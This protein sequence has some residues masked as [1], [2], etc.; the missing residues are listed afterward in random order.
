MKSCFLPLLF[1][2]IL[3]ELFFPGSFIL[4]KESKIELKDSEAKKILLST[5][6]E[7]YEKWQKLDSE[8]EKKAALLLVKNG[9][10]GNLGKYLL[11]DLPASQVKKFIEISITLSKFYL[12]DSVAVEEA[13]NKIEKLT[14]EAAKN[15]AMDWFLKNEIKIKNGNLDIVYLAIDGKSYNAK[16]PYII[17]YHPL[18]NSYAEVTIEIYSSKTTK[19]PKPQSS[20]LLGSYPLEEEVK[21]I[22]P[23]ILRVKGIME[24]SQKTYGGY[25]WVGNPQIEVVF[26][27]S[28]PKIEAE[29]IGFIESWKNKVINWFKGVK[30][31]IDSFVDVI[32]GSGNRAKEQAVS[33]W[34]K[35]GDFFA[36]MSPFTAK[37][38]P[39]FAKEVKNLKESIIEDK[40]VEDNINEE[41]YKSQDNQDSLEKDIGPENLDK[42]QEIIDNIAEQIDILSQKVAE[43][44]DENSKIGDVKIE[45]AEIGVKTENNSDFESEFKPEPEPES[46]FKSDSDSEPEPGAESEPEPASVPASA[47]YS[48]SSGGGGGSPKPAEPSWCKIAG[49]PLQNKII[50]FEVAWMGDTE[51]ANNEWFSLKNISEKSVNLGKWQIFDKDKQIKI[52]I[53]S[54]INIESGEVYL[55]ERGDNYTGALN[56]TDEAL[57]LFNSNCVLQDQVLAEPD[58]PAGDR[59]NKETMKRADDLAWFD[60]PES[61]TDVASESDNGTVE[62]IGEEEEEEKEEEEEEEEEKNKSSSPRILINEIAWSGTKF[63][64]NDEWIELYNPSENPIEIS[65]WELLFKPAEGEER[66]IKISS[67]TETA[68]PTIGGLGYFLME[69][70][71]DNT[72]ADIK[73]DYIYTG[74]LNDE[75]GVLELRDS[76][77][78]LVDKVDCSADWLAGRKEGRISMERLNL[79]NWVDNNLIIQQGKD[80]GGGKIWGTPKSRNSCLISPIQIHEY[81][82]FEEFDEIT[83]SARNNPY[84]ITGRLIIP[85]EKTLII[86]PGAVVKFVDEY[87]SIIV[88]GTLKALGTAESKVVFTSIQENPAPGSWGV[89]AFGASSRN[90]KLDNVIVEYAGGGFGTPCSPNMAGIY[91]NTSSISLTNSIVRHSQ[92]K[93]IHLVNSSSIID[94]V[95][96]IDNVACCVQAADYG[97]FGILVEG[98]TAEPIIRNSLIK[99]SI[100]GIRVIKKASPIIENNNFEENEK[101][102]WAGEEGYPYFSGNTA[103]NNGFNGVVV[104]G[105]INQNTA[106]QANLPYLLVNGVVVAKDA[107]LTIEPGTVVKFFDGYDTLTIAGTLKALGTAEN[108]IVFTSIQEN[109]APGSWNVLA[110]GASSQNSKLDNVIIEYAGGGFGTPCSPDMTAVYVGANSI[111]LTNSIIRHS[112][113]KG[114]SLINSNSYLNNVEVSDTIKCMDT[115]GGYGVFIEGGNNTLENMIF[116]NNS[117]NIFKDGKCLISLPDPILDTATP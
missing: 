115:Y 22:P 32:R 85:E 28:V 104:W 55:F 80:A 5:N 16:F 13:V 34:D 23:F 3:E 46:E 11:F 93:G 86:E 42:M 87:D 109:P 10:E 30:T 97:G 67:M 117:C 37:I 89:L 27:E 77:G 54:S 12:G 105:M 79:E 6:N 33:V 18:D 71:D 24:N 91:V 83:F 48:S 94:N 112:Q 63:S 95:Q 66:I 100:V 31:I 25:W 99:G 101:A 73:A 50:F 59:E 38:S 76:N 58:W 2:V 96:L 35:A 56:N 43:I 21:D 113:Y 81:L 88:V 7:L 90:S 114:I 40:M 39:D 70:T 68:T 107:V 19:G 106:W 36:P 15:Y 8:L 29:E 14:I 102:V 74:A 20:Y 116:N 53:G 69:R 41:S 111:S 78:N 45:L 4:A 51:S 9:I 72:I 84:I 65:N 75:G 57:Y 44:K 82:P 17:V 61:I 98:E 47:G 103:E 49:E 62:L 110:F 64:A 108:K 1:L 26:D 60:Y 92:Y 52:E